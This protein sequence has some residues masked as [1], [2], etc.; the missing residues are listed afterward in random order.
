MIDLA[1]ITCMFAPIDSK[2]FLATAEVCEGSLSITN[3]F[4][5]VSSFLV[6]SKRMGKRWRI[7]R[8]KYGPSMFTYG[9]TQITPCLCA[10]ATSKCN[11]LPP[12]SSL[13]SLVVNSKPSLPFRQTRFFVTHW[14]A[15]VDEGNAI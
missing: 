11:R 9:S 5:L 12:A 14:I 13:L 3:N 6:M 15:F 7:K 1:G 10:I 4:G 8:A 2:G